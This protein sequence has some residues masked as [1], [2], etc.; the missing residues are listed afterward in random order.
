MLIEFQRLLI[1]LYGIETQAAHGLG[2]V[3][4]LLIELYGIETLEREE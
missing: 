1:E 4:Q 3:S 2:N